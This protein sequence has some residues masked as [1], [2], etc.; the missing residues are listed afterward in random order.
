MRNMFRPGLAALAGLFSGLQIALERNAG[1]LKALG[2]AAQ[3]EKRRAKRRRQAARRA[4]WAAHFRS[5]AGRLDD[6]GL[7][8]NSSGDKLRRQAAQGRVGLP[9]AGRRSP[10]LSWAA[11]RTAGRAAQPKSKRA[12]Y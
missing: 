7:P 3:T 5:P 2:G 8:H 12:A 9:A 11:M 1:A 6:L 10:L 4:K